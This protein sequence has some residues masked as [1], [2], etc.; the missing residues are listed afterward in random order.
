MMCSFSLHKQIQTHPI[1]SFCIKKWKR[2]FPET[3][4]SVQNSVP[5]PQRLKM[6]WKQVPTDLKHLAT[7]YK[8]SL[9]N[10]LPK[11]R[12][13]NSFHICMYSRRKM[14]ARI[15]AQKRCDIWYTSKPPCSIFCETSKNIQLKRKVST[16]DKFGQVKFLCAVKNQTY[17][18]IKT[19]RKKSK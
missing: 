12:A 2:M 9:P 10:Q 4:T 11:F 19:K 8:K 3:R 16:A 7:N 14:R 17:L 1:L 13:W 5:A 6:R 15:H 18:N